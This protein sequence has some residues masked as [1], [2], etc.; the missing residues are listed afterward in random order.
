MAR[1]SITSAGSERFIVS[2][3]GDDVLV[4]DT[5]SQRVTSLNPFAAAVWRAADE[6]ADAEAV[7]ARLAV[8]GLGAAER[9][10]VETAL[11]M[12][13]AAGLLGA[14]PVAAEV[15]DQSRRALFG[16]L[17]IGGAVAAAVLTP[18]VATIIAPTPAQ[19][20]S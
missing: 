11:A 9:E 5:T 1:F 4:Y 7:M 6:D 12:L 8:D 16:R 13:G 2:P 17:A 15:V 18:A 10:A 20:A 3:A 19:A 14:P